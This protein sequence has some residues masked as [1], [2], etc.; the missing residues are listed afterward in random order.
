MVFKKTRLA[1]TPSGFLH[2]GNLYS[3]LL[4]A[5]LAKKHR[6]KILLRIDDMDRERM[7]HEYLEDIFESLRQ[8]DIAWDDGPKDPDE[9]EK[10]YSQ[11]LRLP[12]YESLLTELRAS[13]RVFACNCSR[14]G[15]GENG[16]AMAYPGT[17][18]YK[19][20]SLD[21]PDCC[22]RLD[23]RELFS[24]PIQVYG[25]SH[26]EHS[27][28]E[29]MQYFIVRKKDHYPAYQLCSLADDLHFGVDLIVRGQD[30]WD[31][32]LAQLYLA[33]TLGLSAF[34]IVTFV[35]HPL[36]LGDRGE[37]L[38]KS[39]GDTSLRMLRLKGLK[40]KEIVTHLLGLVSEK[41]GTQNWLEML[42]DGSVF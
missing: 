27:L 33:Q 5:S 26:E 18:L 15:L 25:K 36:L 30:L 4:T 16:P 3:F 22:W 13:G 37:K 31:S 23:T 11:H 2:L 8:F 40:P 34:S 41:H 21:E 35:H 19:G 7:R 32:S 38:S 29:N 39:A 9:L 1:P 6:A 17:C 24:L 42:R 20:L 10:Q 12:F 28:P 14:K